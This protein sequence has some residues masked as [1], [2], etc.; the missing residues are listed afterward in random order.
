MRSMG[1]VAVPVVPW[2]SLA[3]EIGVTLALTNVMALVAAR[4][5][6]LMRTAE[7]LRTP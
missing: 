4:R 2:T 6:S 7:V 5:V 1:V 3:I